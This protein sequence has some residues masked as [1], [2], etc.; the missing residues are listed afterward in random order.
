VLHA[1]TLHSQEARRKG[2]CLPTLVEF[3]CPAVAPPGGVGAFA[4]GP[5]GDAGPWLPHGAAAEVPHA[6]AAV[7]AGGDYGDSS[8]RGGGTAAAV[9]RPPALLRAEG[10]VPYWMA[11]P[12][13][14]Q[15]PSGSHLP[16]ND[17]GND[18]PEEE[19]EEE[20]KEGEGPSSSGSGGGC[21]VG[22]DVF[23]SAGEL[24]LLT[25]P[26]MSG[27]STLM[28]SLLAASLLANCGLRVPARSFQ[29]PRFDAFFLRAAGGDSPAEVKTAP[30]P[31]EPLCV[32]E[33]IR[34]LS[35]V[36]SYFSGNAV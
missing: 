30:P 33:C 1:L 6:G 12:P 21:G 35:V 32:R 11:L 17:R 13:R 23:L 4:A 7:V 24:V 25:A 29:A 15:K 26:N 14:D 2:W 31:Y 36:P 18:F 16:G 9:A 27:K 8:G 34:R 22:N 28:R 19:E 10:L 20:E 5:R 3:P